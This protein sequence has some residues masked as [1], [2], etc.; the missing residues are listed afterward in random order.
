MYIINFPL[1]KYV[2]RKFF[3]PFFLNTNV[4]PL[5]HVKIKKIWKREDYVRKNDINLFQQIQY[6]R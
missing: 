2:I 3:N 4:C 1:Y 6:L 5:K